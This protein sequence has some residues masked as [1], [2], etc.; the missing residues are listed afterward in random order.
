MLLLSVREHGGIFVAVLFTVGKT[1][2]QP[3]C[4]LTDERIK[5]L[6]CLYTMQYYSA[7]KRHIRVNSSDVDEPSS[8]YREGSKSDREKQI[9]YINALLGECVTSSVVS[10]HS[11]DLKW[12]TSVT[13]RLQLRV[14][15]GKQRKV[16]PQGVRVGRPRRRGLNPSW[17]PLFIRLSPPLLEPALCKL[18]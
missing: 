4:P 16:H 10:R 13:A 14:L 2:K 3:S 1:W 15:L 7:I 6:W 8:W 11:K 12:Q 9:F 17:L 18:G 5:K